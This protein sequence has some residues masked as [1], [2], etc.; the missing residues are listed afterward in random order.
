[1]REV[2]TDEIPLTARDQAL[3]GRILRRLLVALDDLVVRRKRDILAGPKWR[4]IVLR[5]TRNRLAGDVKAFRAGGAAPG[6]GA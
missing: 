2:L 1:L 4:R 6:P 3:V 5:L